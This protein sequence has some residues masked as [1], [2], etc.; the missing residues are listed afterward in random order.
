M[1]KQI[2]AEFHCHTSWSKDSRQKP[3]DLVAACRRKGIGRV[4]VTDHNS[5]RGALEAQQIDP[6]LVVV[7]EEIMTTRGEILAAYVTEE[8]PAG[9]DP[10]KVIG[11]LREQGAFI[12]VSHPLDR[13]RSGAWKKQDLDQIID[14]VDAL[15]VFNARCWYPEDNDKTLAYAREHGVAGTAGSDAHAGFELGTAMLKILPFGNAGELKKHLTDS[16]VVGKMSPHWV[17][18]VSRWA[19]ITKKLFQP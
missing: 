13:I 19:T 4:V 15:E 16:E 8:I 1:E 11:L 18:L 5:I 9:L 6:E 7:G 3:A 14:Q 12:S 2:L 10:L 17:H